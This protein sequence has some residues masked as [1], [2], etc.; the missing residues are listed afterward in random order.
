MSSR[1]SNRDPNASS[2]NLFTGEE[3]SG[4][5]P[6]TQRSAF[7]KTASSFNLFTGE[8]ING[9]NPAYQQQQQMQQQQMQ[10]RAPSSNVWASNQSQNCG[11]ML[12][13]RPSTLVSQAPGGRSSFTIG[14]PD[15]CVGARAR[16]LPHHTTNTPRRVDDR[17]A[18]H[19][20]RSTLQS[21]ENYPA[22]QEP[23]Y[24]DHQQCVFTAHSSPECCGI[25]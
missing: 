9:C 14:D 18:A 5:A 6:S 22:Y 10:Q 19:S 7:Q 3:T 25:V 1:R 4:A 2:F 21:R 16:A 8:E 24:N 17:F 15:M 23:A 12:S 13:E 20:H 11:N